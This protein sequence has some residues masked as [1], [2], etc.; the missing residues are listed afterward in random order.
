MN[1]LDQIDL[2]AITREMTAARESVATD[3]LTRRSLFGLTATTFLPRIPDQREANQR[4]LESFGVAYLYRHGEVWIDW[5]W[6]P[7]PGTWGVATVETSEL[8]RAIRETILPA[9]RSDPSID[10]R[11]PSPQFA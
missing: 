4:L 2:E 3:R 7:N 5:P 8:L 11:V 1:D 9:R 10:D 6:G